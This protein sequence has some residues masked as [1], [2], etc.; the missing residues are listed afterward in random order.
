MPISEA[1]FYAMCQCGGCGPMDP[2]GLCNRNLQPIELE[3][4]DRS[5]EGTYFPPASAGPTRQHDAAVRLRRN[6]RGGPGGEDDDND[7]GNSGWAWGGGAAQRPPPYAVGARAGGGGD[8]G[9]DN[10]QRL[11]AWFS[12]LGKAIGEGVSQTV[13]KVKEAANQ[14]VLARTSG[15]GSAV[16]GFGAAADAV[17]S[18]A[19]GRKGSAS[20]LLGRA[21]FEGGAGS[22]VAG[23]SGSGVYAKAKHGG[24]A[25]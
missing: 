17:L 22:S 10:G 5:S 14:P 25:D 15:N 23:G 8:S 2:N 12:E 21:P 1:A 7:S 3:L 19:R 18:S 6:G 11:A 9:S 24:K 13:A 20:A 4:T 16:G